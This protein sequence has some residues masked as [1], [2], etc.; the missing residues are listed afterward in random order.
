MIKVNIIGCFGSYFLY[1]SLFGHFNKRPFGVW[2]EKLDQGIAPLVLSFGLSLYK[3]RTLFYE[4][5]NSSWNWA[6]G[7]FEWFPFVGMPSSLSWTVWIGCPNL[8]SVGF[9]WSHLD[10]WAAHINQVLDSLLPNS[11]WIDSHFSSQFLHWYSFQF[12]CFVW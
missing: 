9:T 6:F 12:K 8:G 7:S 2:C 4:H 5:F 11:R 10:D 1:V 3:S